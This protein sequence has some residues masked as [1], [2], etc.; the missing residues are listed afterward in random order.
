MDFSLKK[1]G[2]LRVET[3]K[4]PELQMLIETLNGGWQENKIRLDP[5]V[6]PKKISYE[7]FIHS[8]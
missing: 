4:D 1:F 6:I 2:Q 3:E 8:S 7:Y 5:L